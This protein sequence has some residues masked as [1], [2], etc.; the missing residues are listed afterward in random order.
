MALREYPD[1]EW[2]IQLADEVITETYG[3]GY[4]FKARKS[5]EEVEYFIL[6]EDPRMDKWI[7][8]MASQLKE[9]INV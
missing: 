5:G 4:I 3:D 1:I 6:I 9:K 8:L 2:V 7:H